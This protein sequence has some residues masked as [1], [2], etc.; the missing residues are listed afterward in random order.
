M[1]ASARRG[2]GP[3]RLPA[4]PATLKGRM[5]LIVV[6][7]LAPPL[8]LSAFQTWDAFRTESRRQVEEAGRLLDIVAAQKREFLDKTLSLLAHLAGREE[9]RAAGRRCTELLRQAREQTP[10]YGNFL[11]TDGA[12]TGLCGSTP[13]LVGRDFSDR[14]YVAALRSGRDVAISG[15]LAGRDGLGETIVVARALRDAPG[16]PLTG[17]LAVSID[18]AAFTRSTRTMDLPP[19]TAVYLLDRD[20]EL[21]GATQP[22]A[23]EKLA[24]APVADD[25]VGLALSPRQILRLTGR[26]GRERFYMAAP[27]ADGA[28]YVVVGMP[29]PPRF[30][31]LEQ[32]LGRGLL[33]PTIMLSLAV[34]AMWLAVDFLVNRHIRAL[35]E[36]AHAYGRGELDRHAELAGAPEELGTLA[37]TLRDM[38]VRVK[39]REDEL[40][41]SL[42]QKD[43]L[44]REIHHRIKN[45]LQ[46]VTSLLSLRAR[47]LASAEARR[48]MDEAQLRIRAL[49]LVHR[50]LYEQDSTRLVPLDSF[51]SDL[52]ELLRVL[53]PEDGRPVRFDV[54]VAPVEIASDQAIPLALFLTEAVCNAFRH[55][56]TGVDRPACI[57]IRLEVREGEVELCVADNGRGFD[58]ASGEGQGI[59]LRLMRMLAGQL[60]GRCSFENGDGTVVRLAFP[61]DR[62]KHAPA[63]GTE[64][65]FACS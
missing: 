58:P 57:E 53:A 48:V 39:Q 3:L 11:L 56:F 26:D 8:F 41:A 43:V 45:N 51:L 60:G 24:S 15:R 5:V 42:Q 27:I 30:A 21:L 35:A 54:D 16:G 14:D 19:E 31:W 1:S 7:V 36:V 29:A 63:E 59:G 49:A 55:A 44:L 52:L 22:G 65:A 37:R 4:G 6:F 28:L 18:I 62:A 17:V 32:R 9:I 50:H 61:L 25:L 47:G 10:E 34:V 46:I 23:A 40:I 13:A 12:G 2:A 20:G 64:P 33:A 38:A